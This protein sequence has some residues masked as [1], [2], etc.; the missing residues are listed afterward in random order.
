MTQVKKQRPLF[1]T[2]NQTP[3]RVTHAG[4]I[5]YSSYADNKD[6]DSIDFWGSDR[7]YGRITPTSDSIFPRNDRLR[8]VKYAKDNKTVFLL[9]FVADAWEDLVLAMRDY[10]N[11]GRVVTDSPWANLLAYRGYSDVNVE[12]DKHFKNILFPSL[13]DE[14]LALK[15]KNIQVSDLRGFL[16]TISP[17]FRHIAGSVPITKSGFIQSKFCPIQCSG[18]VVE[19]GEELYSEDFYKAEKYY[20][21]NNFSFFLDIAKK[22]GFMID[23]NIPWRL[24]ADVSSPAMRKRMSAYIDP[25]DFFLERVY[26]YYSYRDDIDNLKVYLFDMYETF[27]SANPY[28]FDYKV[29]SGCTSSTALERKKEDFDQQFGTTGTYAAR[30][31]LKTYF[32]LRSLEMNRTAPPNSQIEDL[33]LVYDILDTHGFYDALYYLHT[34]IL[35]AEKKY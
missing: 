29:N 28:V 13:S 31:H 6:G 15:K 18:L 3:S 27:R 26:Y 34:H 20:E 11:K 16:K 2:S 24:V 33:R 30:W 7:L 35:S 19:V 4:R 22:H 1:R 5:L 21:D 23:K 10:A 9:D 32:L 8:Q 12:Y 25:N 17:L 14:Y